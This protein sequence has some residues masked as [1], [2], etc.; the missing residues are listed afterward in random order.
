MILNKIKEI[1]IAHDIQVIYLIKSGSMLYSTNPELTLENLM[2]L[3]EKTLDNV[4]RN[5][6]D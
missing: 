3:L 5:Y 2:V 1:E 4:N 6:G